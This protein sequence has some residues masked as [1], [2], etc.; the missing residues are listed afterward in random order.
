MTLIYK[1]LGGIFHWVANTSSN[2]WLYF[3]Q[4]E[5]GAKDKKEWKNGRKRG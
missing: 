4:R 5:Q 3:K 1:L 2:C